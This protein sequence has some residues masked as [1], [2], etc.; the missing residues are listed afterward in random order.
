MTLI[1]IV[2][3]QKKIICEQ[4]AINTELFNIVSQYITAAEA[5][6]L[7]AGFEIGG[8]QYEE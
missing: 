6:T 5:E 7:H 8:G 2:E 3:Q 4:Q 1:E